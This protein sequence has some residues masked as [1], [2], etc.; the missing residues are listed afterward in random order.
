MTPKNPEQ[1]KKRER[2][3][4][5]AGVLLMLSPVCNFFL[6]VYFLDTANNKWTAEGLS[7][8]LS[9][10]S[11]VHL[12][13]WASSFVVGAFML[14]GRRSSWIPVLAILGMFIVFNF[15][16]LK[17]DLQRSSTRPFILLLTNMAIFGLVY[18]QEFHQ[19]TQPRVKKPT[20]EPKPEDEKD[21]PVLAS[22]ATPTAE[23][24]RESVPENFKIDY[25]TPEVAMKK[26]LQDEVT[27]IPE[28]INKKEAPTPKFEIQ[29]PGLQPEVVGPTSDKTVAEEKPL[30]AKKKK[31]PRYT[32]YVVHIS[33]LLN[34]IVEFEGH[35]PWARITEANL[36]ELTMEAIGPTPPEIERRRVEIVLRDNKVLKLKMA[37]Q[38]GP[39]YIFTYRDLAKQ[40]A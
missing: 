33:D 4:Q 14:K 2:L 20:K 38:M 19:S 1:L 36:T 18:S 8:I 13:L 9:N 40:S 22:A 26:S 17:K 27:P 30:I 12:F 28:F 16:N 15:W 10:T 29:K 39:K 7:I 21:K 5:I 24:P 32:D 35:G 37:R 34:K 3:I 25:G 23:V 11:P 6:S 31:K